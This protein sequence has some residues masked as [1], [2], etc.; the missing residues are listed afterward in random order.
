MPGGDRVPLAASGIADCSACAA[1]NGAKLSN[2][3]ANRRPRRIV[4]TPLRL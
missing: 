1:A 2:A 3:A 4:I